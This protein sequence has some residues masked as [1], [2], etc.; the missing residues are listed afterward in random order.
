MTPD[1]ERLERYLEWRRAGS[2]E[3]AARRRRVVGYVAAPVLCVIAVGVAAWL[4]RTST[5]PETPVTAAVPP[6]SSSTPPPSASAPSPAAPG[7]PPTGDLPT[8]STPGLPRPAPPSATHARSEPARA[9]GASPRAR[10]APA[11][12][13]LPE[14]DESSELSAAVAPPETPREAP[15]E[16]THETIALPRETPV[17]A[18]TGVAAEAAPTGPALPDTVVSPALARE[19]DVP[20]APAATAPSGGAVAVAPPTVRDRVTDWLEGEVQEFRDGVKREVGELRS[21][22]EKVRGLF[23]R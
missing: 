14:R 11:L 10:V 8:R 19:D 23:K 1:D 5:G 12:P 3:R 18:P 9:R 6:P 20:A 15:P 22:Y 2:R 13:A 4:G 21:G 7:P 16:S 17:E